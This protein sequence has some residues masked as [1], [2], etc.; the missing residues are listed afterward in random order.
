MSTFA[1]GAAQPNINLASTG[2]LGPSTNVVIVPW[3]SITVSTLSSS[4]YYVQLGNPQDL[5]G[6][7]AKDW[8]VTKNTPGTISDFI[9]SDTRTG[10]AWWANTCLQSGNEVSVR[11]AFLSAFELIPPSNVPVG[12]QGCASG[13]QGNNDR[14]ETTIFYGGLQPSTELWFRLSWNGVTTLTLNSGQ[15]MLLSS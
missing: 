2:G 5:N 3:S 7:A 10:I 14:N 8:I 15:L 1:S 6:D 12:V 11:R 9:R 13:F 4:I